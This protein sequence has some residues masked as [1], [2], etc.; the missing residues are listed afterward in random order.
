VKNSQKILLKI[1]IEDA[2]VAMQIYKK[3][4][5]T[6]ERNKKKYLENF[7]EPNFSSGY[8][9][10]RYQFEYNNICHFGDCEY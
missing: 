6:W 1:K 9:E 10:D 2:Q 4:T 5:K 8:E 3:T 7:D